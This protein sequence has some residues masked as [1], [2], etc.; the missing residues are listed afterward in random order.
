[1]A[2]LQSRSF[3]LCVALAALA[4]GR[5]CHFGGEDDNPASVS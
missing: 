3:L 5:G 1:V 2:S 4:L